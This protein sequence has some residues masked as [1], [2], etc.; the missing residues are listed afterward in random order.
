MGNTFCHYF[1]WSTTDFHTTWWGGENKTT[2]DKSDWLVT[3]TYSRLFRGCSPFSQ[4]IRKFRFEV[5]WSV[6]FPEIPFGNC[7]VLSEV[8]L[9]FRSERNDGN[10][11][12]ISFDLSPTVSKTVYQN[13]V[14]GLISV[15]L[16]HWWVVPPPTGPPT[17]APVKMF[18]FAGL[19]MS[20]VCHDYSSTPLLPKELFLTFC[21]FLAEVSLIIEKKSVF[22]LRN[23][24]PELRTWNT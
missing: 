5:K 18:S 11:L 21:F 23:R 9:F 14:A 12:T 22:F 4:K 8:L 2:E 24:E 7:G 17:N 10:F 3:C 19:D 16:K 6:S 15:Y 20:R 1:D 13:N